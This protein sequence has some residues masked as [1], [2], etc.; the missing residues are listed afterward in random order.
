LAVS[1]WAQ[2]QQPF[3]WW[4]AAVMVRTRRWPSFFIPLTRSVARLQ[5]AAQLLHYCLWLEELQPRAD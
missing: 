1:G 4:A 2:P 3:G 5:S